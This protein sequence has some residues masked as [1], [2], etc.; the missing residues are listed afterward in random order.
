MPDEARKWLGKWEYV[1]NP[2]HELLVHVRRLLAENENLRDALVTIVRW[3]DAYPL[4]VFPEPDF[5]KA[6][7]LLQNGGMTLDAISAS[8]MRHV[9]EGIGRITKEALDA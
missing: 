1:F 6:R 8:N 2:E 7:Q 4:D 9:V 3:S 5:E